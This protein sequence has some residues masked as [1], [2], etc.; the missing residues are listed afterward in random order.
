MAPSL[1]NSTVASHAV[2]LDIG[3]KRMAK[4]DAQ[5][6]GIEWNEAVGRAIQAAVLECGWSNKEA[7]AK[8][9]VDAADFG[10]WVSGERRAHFDRLLAVPEMRKPLAIQFWKLAG[11]R[12]RVAAEF[13]DAA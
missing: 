1:A 6:M 12:V 7:A 9:G 5:E 13:E 3:K 8:V 10:K 2:S 4:V 11:G